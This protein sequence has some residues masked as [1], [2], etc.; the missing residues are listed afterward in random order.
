MD[1]SINSVGKTYQK[2]PEHK[3]CSENQQKAEFKRPNHI[4]NNTR[5]IQSVERT[6]L[7]LE[8]LSL[9]P[10][11]LSLQEISVSVG[12]NKTTAHGLLATLHSLGYVIKNKAGYGLGLRFRELSKP[13]EQK[14]EAIRSHFYPLIERMAKMTDN[15][16]YLAVQSG[17]QEYLYIDA[18]EK[19]NPLTIRSPRGKRE[20]LISSAIGKVFL[21]FDDSLLRHL[22]LKGQVSSQ[23]EK[24]LAKV[25][26]RGFALDLEQAEPNLHCLAIPLYQEGELVA[27][28]GV[29]GDAKELTQARLEHFANLFLSK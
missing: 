25:K 27:V 12:L 28:A 11:E 24:E 7:I 10:T 19:N 14:D 3:Q 18:V 16:A 9:S 8:T 20:G 2:K 1:F 21:S 5:N 4:V 22:R 13:L 6:F 15:T 17:V 23:L 29:S 26:K